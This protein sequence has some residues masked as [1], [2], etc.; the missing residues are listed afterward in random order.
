MRLPESAQKKALRSYGLD[1]RK[2]NLD[3]SELGWLWGDGKPLSSSE[4]LYLETQEE[5]SIADWLW[6][7]KKPLEP[8][9]SLAMPQQ[10]TF[11]HWDQNIS[12]PILIKKKKQPAKK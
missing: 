7:N 2:I 12:R 11:P 6:G 10:L 3:T 9:E 8:N 1:K 5:T 4:I